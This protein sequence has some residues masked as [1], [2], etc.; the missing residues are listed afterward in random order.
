MPALIIVAAVAGFVGIIIGY[1]VTPKITNAQL[2]QAYCKGK[3]SERQ[4][5]EKRL[6]AMQRRIWCLEAAVRKVGSN[7]ST[8]IKQPV[9]LAK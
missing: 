2:Y 7:A 5:K 6:Y 3:L 1:A 4:H 9:E 8:S